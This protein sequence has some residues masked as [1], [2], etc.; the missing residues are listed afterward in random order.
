M[1]SLKDSI[2]RAMK[3]QLDPALQHV[4]EQEERVERQ[5]QRAARLRRA[6]PPLL[7]SDMNLI[8]TDNVARTK[9]IDAIGQWSTVARD[10]PILILGGAVGRG[11][12]FAAAYALAARGG[13]YIGAQEIV[14]IFAAQFGEEVNDQTRAL[15]CRCLVLDDVGTELNRAAMAHVLLR[16]V[17]ERRQHGR[18]TVITTNFPR[19][20]FRKEYNDPRLHSRLDQSSVYVADKG[21]DMRAEP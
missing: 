19:S 14:R 4:I 9:F 3:A 15:S 16:C 2:D 20:A 1:D 10:K 17:D 6:A 12:S 5:Q 13:M 11:K 21:D 18:R 8:I 7:D